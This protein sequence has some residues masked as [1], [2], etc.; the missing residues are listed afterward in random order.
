MCD[1]QKNHY[2]DP[3]QG[4][5][6]YVFFEEFHGLRSYIY[7]F[8]PLELIFVSGVRQG[9]SFILLH[10]N[11]QFSQHHVL[12]RLSFFHS[13]FWLPCQILVDHICLGLFLGSW[14]C[15]IGLFVCWSFL[16]IPFISWWEFRIWDWVFLCVGLD[17]REI[18][19]SIFMC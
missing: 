5:F 12:K 15:S 17:G 9:S 16:I 18:K 8:N 2:Q 13:V 10:V 11:I 19:Q 6:S 7:V 14:F 4:D 1:F 3:C